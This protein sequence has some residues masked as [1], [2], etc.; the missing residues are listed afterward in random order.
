MM[1]S[2]SVV[3]ICYNCLKELPGTVES[4]REQTHSEIE[5]I[6]IDGD[7]D[8]GTA[9]WL[10]E[11]ER[12]FDTLVSEPD[13]GR[14]H[15][16]NKGLERATG[17]YVMFLN[18][19]D[20]LRTNSI[21]ENLLTRPEIR[22]DRPNIISGRIEFTIDG[23]S[24]NFTRPWRSGKEGPGL[25]HPATLVD[26]ELHQLY[27]FDEQFTYVGDYELWARLRDENEFDVRYVSDVLTFFDVEGA[28]N[29]P[30]VAFARYLERAFVDYKYGHGFSSIDAATLL[31]APIARQTL[32]LLLGQ[33]RFVAIL[34]YR[35]LAKRL[36][37]EGP[38][39]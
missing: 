13:E 6:V 1:L 22:E 20:E 39:L 28:S 18:A 4:V 2:L 21:I 5:H 14:Y 27:K 23:E 17:D 10:A 25:P 7:S 8:D 3:T 26:R 33:R 31:F 35:R 30:D 19:G 15:A 12:W 38:K 32:Q 36:L 11:R 37:G 29:S 16:M 9:E 24:L 34:R